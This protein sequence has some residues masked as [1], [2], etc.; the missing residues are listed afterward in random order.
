[1]TMAI[2]CLFTYVNLAVGFSL[3]AVIVKRDLV[4]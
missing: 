1:M 2:F 4:G 3:G